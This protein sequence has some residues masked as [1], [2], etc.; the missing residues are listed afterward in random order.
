MLPPDKV[1]L[2]DPEV[3]A[4]RLLKRLAELATANESVVLS[5]Q[6]FI[7]NELIQATIAARRSLGERGPIVVSRDEA[8]RA[9]PAAARA[10]AEAWS[11][12]RTD[13]LIAADPSNAGG[14]FVTSRGQARVAAA[15]MPANTTDTAGPQ[16]TIPDPVAQR[17]AVPKTGAPTAV[18]SYSHRD[19]DW[20]VAQQQ[21]WEGK[22]LALAALLRSQGV[23]VTIDQYQLRADWARYG[24]RAIRESDFTI[25][26]MSEGYRLAWQ[27]DLPDGTG[28]GARGEIDVLLDLQRDRTDFAQRFIPVLLPAVPESTIPLGIGATITW[29]RVSDFTPDGVEGLL[30]RI[31]DAPAVEIPPLGPRPELPIKHPGSATELR[32]AIMLTEQALAELSGRDEP[33][34]I[35]SSA[36]EDQRGLIQSRLDALEAS[37]PPATTLLPGQGHSSGP[38]NLHAGG[39]FN[40][41][42][43]NSGAAILVSVGRLSSDIGVF[44]SRNETRVEAGAP[45]QLAI[46]APGVETLDQPAGSELELQ[47]EYRSANEDDPSVLRYTLKLLRDTV[48]VTGRPR[49]RAGTERTERLA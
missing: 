47:V 32:N 49:W 22:A 33:A 29:V 7:D 19:P 46:T 42:L 45:V 48:N 13:G 24:P 34:A 9:F 5:E 4:A 2:T 23:D 17:T 3:L 28:A 36:I 41:H 31:F 30:R 21:L 1:C 39:P 8:H 40:A 37:S 11:I 20:S 12:L 44:E 18:I 10:W 26:L 15:E 6:A 25:A 27:D 43:Q 35:A 16:S 14:V 38:F